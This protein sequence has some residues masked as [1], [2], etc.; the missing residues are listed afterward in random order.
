MHYEIFLIKLCP[1]LQ[2]GEIPHLKLSFIDLGDYFQQLKNKKLHLRSL[3]RESVQELIQ[4][5]YQIFTAQFKYWHTN[6][7][8]TPNS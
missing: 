7:R 1:I 4:H 5:H 3:F 2:L 8:S 6:C